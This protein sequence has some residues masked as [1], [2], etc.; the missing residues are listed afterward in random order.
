ML[1]LPINTSQGKSRRF[2]RSNSGRT[3]TMA[4]K[5]TAK[6]EKSRQKAMPTG[7]IPPSR[8]MRLINVPEVD[9]SAL[10]RRTSSRCDC[11]RGSGMPNIHHLDDV[12]FYSSQQRFFG[13][14]GDLNR[15]TP[16]RRIIA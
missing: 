8:E 6:V 1:R 13:D 11:V 5:S 2:T 10:A 7:E 12:L 14:F 4:T 16:F 15:A 3:R 9:H